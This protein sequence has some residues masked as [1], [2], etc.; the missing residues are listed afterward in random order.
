MKCTQFEQLHAKLLQLVEKNKYIALK[1][2]NG[3][4]K[5][6]LFTSEDIEICR[7][8]SKFTFEGFKQ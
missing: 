7:G 3:E 6:Y 8:I 1:S 2:L 5:L 4:K